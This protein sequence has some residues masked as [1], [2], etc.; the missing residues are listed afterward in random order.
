VL[1]LGSTFLRDASLDTKVVT[2]NKQNK[3]RIATRILTFFFSLILFF[4]LFLSFVSATTTFFFSSRIFFELQELLLFFMFFFHL[5]FSAATQRPCTQ[6]FGTNGCS[7][8]WNIHTS[9]KHKYGPK[10][11][12]QRGWSIMKLIANNLV[13]KRNMDLGGLIFRWER[14][15]LIWTGEMFTARLQPSKDAP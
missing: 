7:N 14:I 5:F 4:L 15:S 3:L 6:D 11:R 9:P 8:L 1:V 2:Q 10:L 13:T 12:W